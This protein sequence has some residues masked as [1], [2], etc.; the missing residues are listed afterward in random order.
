M[1]VKRRRASSYKRGTA[2]RRTATKKTYRRKKMTFFMMF[3]K[4][5]YKMWMH[6]FMVKKSYKRSPAKKRAYKRK[7]ITK[8]RNYNSKRVAFQGKRRKAASSKGYS[9]KMAA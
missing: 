1:A 8:R 7:A 5:F 2:G 3:K 4:W 6:M 9:K